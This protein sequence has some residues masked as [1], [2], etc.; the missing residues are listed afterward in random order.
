MISIIIPTLNESTAIR[1]CL[2]A[3]KILTAIEHEIII[4][5]GR[6][7]DD[8]IAICREYTDKIIVY[9][10][11][12]RQTIA[13][14]RNLGA[15]IAHGEI[16][17]FMDADVVV[18]NPNEFFARALEMFDKNSELLGATALLK[19]YL[20]TANREDRFFSWIV[21]ATH[22]LNNNVFKFGS[23]SGEFQMIRRSA[24]EKVG[25]YNDNLVACEDN[26][27]FIRLAKIGKTR[28][29]TDLTVYHSGRRAH[30]VGWVPLLLTW[31][32]NSIHYFLFKKAAARE[33][34]VIR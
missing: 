1:K 7:T 34:T 12:E 33:W 14:G 6:S 23:A 20:D 25:G 22:Y 30:K 31:I 17:V 32:N 15:S 29:A 24:F 8:T 2:D 10:K 11:S 21:N 4:S 28:L 9:N 18:M 5:D 19:V 3:L 27:M 16:L 13:G 26:D